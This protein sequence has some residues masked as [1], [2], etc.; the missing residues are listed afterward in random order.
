VYSGAQE[1]IL[2]QEGVEKV[3]KQAQKKENSL[4]SGV[5]EESKEGSLLGC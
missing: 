5:K 4:S 3:C 1:K 2:R